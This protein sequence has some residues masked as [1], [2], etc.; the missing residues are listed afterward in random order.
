M[1]AKS[2]RLAL[3]TGAAS[4]IGRAIT[5]QFVAE[6]IKVIALDRSEGGLQKLVE[7]TKGQAVN[8]CLFD[9]SETSAIPALVKQLIAK[10]GSITSWSTTQELG[11]TS[12]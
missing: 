6:G 4:G 5:L 3:V 8:P 12:H 9:V 2:V 11:I 1:T 10:H 7:E